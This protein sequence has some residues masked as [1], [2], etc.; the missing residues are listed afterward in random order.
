MDIVL[1]QILMIYFYTQREMYPFTLLVKA[2]IWNRWLL[3]LWTTVL[4]DQGAEI[5]SL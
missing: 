5:N 2:S 1:N 3:K 4:T